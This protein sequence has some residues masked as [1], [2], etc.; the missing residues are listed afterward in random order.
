MTVPILS[1]IYNV[2]MH[3]HDKALNKTFNLLQLGGCTCRWKVKTHTE[4]YMATASQFSKK[5]LLFGN[6]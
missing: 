4:H 3:N 5:N 2:T 1:L 6:Y